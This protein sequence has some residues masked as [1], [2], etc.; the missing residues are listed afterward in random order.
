MNFQNSSEKGL[1][2]MKTAIVLGGTLFFGKH[3]VQDLLD[4]G[5]EVTIATRGKTPDPFGDKVRRIQLDRE[6]RETVKAAADTGEWDLL[7]DQTCYSPVEAKETMELFAG[8]IK[9]YIFTSTM[10]VYDFAAKRTEANFDP[11][12]YPFSMGS[13][14]EYL[15]L[16]GYQ[17]AKRSGEAVLFQEAPFE[18]VAV[19]FPLVIGPDDYTKRFA[20]HVDRV[21]QGLPI[22][23]PNPD[24]RYS[25][26]SSVDAGKFL[27]WIGRSELTG[28]YNAG[29]S[30]DISIYEILHRIKEKQGGTIDVVPDGEAEARSPYAFSTDLSIDVSKAVAAG[31]TFEPLDS[32]LE[33][34]LVE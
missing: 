2:N 25:F 13:R 17:E 15:G 26:I 12:T 31:F 14:R 3:L 32:L 4:H 19:R 34:L 7:F 20:F 16:Q 11:A 1:T 5:Y 9:R 29:C 28:T 8:K 18:V 21:K 30:D 23:A 33:R 24:A 6:Q 10:A 22:V 27:S